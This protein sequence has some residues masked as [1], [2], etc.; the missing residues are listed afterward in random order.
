MPIPDVPITGITPNEAATLEKIQNFHQRSWSKIDPLVLELRRSPL[1]QQGREQLTIRLE[2]LPFAP[3]DYG[4]M[5][6][7]VGPAYSEGGSNLKR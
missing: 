6:S 1:K 4:R 3:E 5:L 2:M 7:V